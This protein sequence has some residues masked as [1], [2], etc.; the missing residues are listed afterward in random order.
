MTNSQAA[1]YESWLVRCSPRTPDFSREQ[2]A[3]IPL[4]L[5]ESADAICTQPRDPPP[6]SLLHAIFVTIRENIW[7][8]RGIK[9]GFRQWEFDIT[10]TMPVGV[11]H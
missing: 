3:S 8:L 9:P 5:Q 7:L 6:P 2:S 4:I 11:R 1:V 10:T